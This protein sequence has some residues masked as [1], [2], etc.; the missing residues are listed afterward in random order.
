MHNNASYSFKCKIKPNIIII[1]KNIT[2]HANHIIDNASYLFLMIF[3]CA[4]FINAMTN[5]L[6]DEKP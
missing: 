3:M 2:L 6:S 4:R 5:S 1:A